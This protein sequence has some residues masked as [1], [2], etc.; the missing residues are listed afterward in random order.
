M[1]RVLCNPVVVQDVANQLGLTVKQV[2]EIIGCQSEFTKEVMSGI[3]FD[4]V[5]W[6]YLGIFKSKPKE[7]QM[8]NHLRGM[9]PEQ[10][11]D[12]KRKVRTK[13]IIL[14]H[15]EKP[16]KND[17][18]KLRLQPTTRDSRAVPYEADHA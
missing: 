9:T 7:V 3:N 13:Q 11:E 1:E 6:P 16:K 14:N 4:S 18:S 2:K 8:I 10:Q 17:R 5:R 15:W 12:F